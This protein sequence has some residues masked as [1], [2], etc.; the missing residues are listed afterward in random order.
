MQN[1]G[2]ITIGVIG[3]G[4]FSRFFID[5]LKNNFPNLSI[6][7][8]SRSNEVDNKLFF[9]YT[10]VV[11]SDIVIPAVPISVFED[12]IIELA[13]HIK[14]GSLVIDICSVKVYPIKTMLK[15]LPQST[16]IIATHPM[17][18]PSS[19]IKK[20]S[21]ENFNLVIKNIR[22]KQDIYDKVINLLKILKLKIIEFDE[23]EHDRLMAEFQFLS[24]I[25]AATLK[26]L[27][28][29]RSKIITASASVLLDFVD[30][31][32]VDERLIEDSYKYNPYCKEQLERFELSITNLINKL[33]S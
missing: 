12:T 23:D 27:D 17:F 18:G 4:S 16:Q 33:K 5:V 7:V 14:K 2:K 8:Y 1:K 28:I 22:C 21:L 31:V 15:Y 6:K 24:W 11:Q 3:Y 9:D 20:G 19:F 32:G 26:P 13:K 30:M 10:T 29:K 25:T